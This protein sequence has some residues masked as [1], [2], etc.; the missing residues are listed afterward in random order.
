MDDAIIKFVKRKY[1]F[2]I[3][4]STAED[5]KIKIGKAFP[6]LESYE[7]EVRGRDALN[8]LPG[9][10][11]ITSDDIHEAI[12]QILQ[13]IVL[14]LRQILEE[15]PPE[16]AADIMDTGVVLTGGG[17]L[18]RGLPDLIIQETGI[19]TIVSED[20]RTCVVKGIG[21]L[22]ESDKHLQRVAINHNK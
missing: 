15:T 16:I 13:D 19:K 1:K 9:N 4:S 5:V 11:R 14:N 2:L 3:G 18:I 8:G 17:S 12:S 10:I 20:P 21:E 6:T 7:L 22:L